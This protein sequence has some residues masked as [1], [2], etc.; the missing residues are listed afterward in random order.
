MKNMESLMAGVLRNFAIA[1]STF[2]ER[3]LP[4]IS[5]NWWEDAVLNVLSLQ[6]RRFVKQKNISSLSALDL[7]AL[8]RIF[9][10]N[11]HLIGPK[12]NFPSEQRH[13]VKEMQTVRNRWAHAGSEGFSNDLIYRDLDTIQRFASM[14]ESPDDLIATIRELKESILRKSGRSQT[15]LTG[16]GPETTLPETP[17]GFE[18]TMGQI[19]CLKSNPSLKGAIVGIT[20]SEPENRYA[21]FMEGSI[22]TFYASQLQAEE[23]TYPSLLWQSLTQFHSYLTALHLRHPSLSTVNYNRLK[24][25]A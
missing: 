21:V 18:F 25:V 12:Q 13:F 11:W 24:A 17:Q 1:L 3:I 20:P 10:Q 23:A 9:D 5:D 2:L 4:E 22:G 14:I 8:I 16:P 15:I 6:Q 19:V 7:A